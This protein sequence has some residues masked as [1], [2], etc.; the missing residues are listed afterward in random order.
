MIDC[1]RETREKGKRCKQI[2]IPLD[3]LQRVITHLLLN[4]LVN[5]ERCSLSDLLSDLLGCK[6]RIKGTGKSAI[7]D[8]AVELNSLLAVTHLQRHA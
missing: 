6:G 1:C 8:G 3:L 4:R 5:E 7:Y 2:E